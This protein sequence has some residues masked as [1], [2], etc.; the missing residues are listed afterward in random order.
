LYLR[1][2]SRA[3][4]CFGFGRRGLSRFLI[5]VVGEVALIGGELNGAFGWSSPSRSSLKL[6]LRCGREGQTAVFA[7]GS[8]P[9]SALNWA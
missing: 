8:E 2:S 1:V 7:N 5:S 9:T 3:F 6:R 4:F